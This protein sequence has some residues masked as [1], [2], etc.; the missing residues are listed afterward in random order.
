MFEILLL[1]VA[2]AFLMLFF[3]RILIKGL[4]YVS[5]WI[6]SSWASQYL[7]YFN[8]VKILYYGGW[9]ITLSGC[10]LLCFLFDVN[11]SFFD[12]IQLNGYYVWVIWAYFVLFR[13]FT[14]Q[15]LNERDS[16]SIDDG[17]LQRFN[18]FFIFSAI[19]WAFI[20]VLATV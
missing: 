6:D 7:K 20:L 1:I 15:A 2:F 13:G 14:G 19:F 8:Y 12:N 17:F 16:L 4:A 9:L 18:H 10:L 3:L 11:A 5:Q